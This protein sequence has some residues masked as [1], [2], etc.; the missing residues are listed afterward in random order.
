V[1]ASRLPAKAL[2][3]QWLSCTTNCGVNAYACHDSHPAQVGCRFASESLK[4]N[5]FDLVNLGSLG[6]ITLHVPDGKR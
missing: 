4:I 5:L 3:P 6:K 1:R 2:T